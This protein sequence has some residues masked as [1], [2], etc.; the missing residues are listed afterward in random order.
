MPIL[1]KL[2]PVFLLPLGLALICLALGVVLRRR[3]PVIAAAAIL[4]V[5][6]I[7]AFSDRLLGWLE[8]I[9]PALAVEATG[10]ADAVVVLSGMLGPP[11]A[12]GCTL[13]LGDAWDRFEGGMALLEARRAEWLVFT[14]G[15]VPWEKRPQLEGDELKALASRRGLPAERI[16]VTREVGNTADEAR[17]VAELMREKKWR[18]VILVT[19]GWHL[20]RA[21]LQFR[22]AGVEHIP[23]PVDLRIDPDKTM[24]AVDWVPRASALENTETALRELYGYAFYRLRQ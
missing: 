20:P 4:Y 3:W 23:F 5:G 24:S 19:T 18:R 21:S 12:P 8:R 2:L 10:P 9:Y 13:N 6:S 11:P 14:G 16:L 1:N 22:R 7:E 15:K 17:A